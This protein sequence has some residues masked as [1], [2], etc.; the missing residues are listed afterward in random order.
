MS[1]FGIVLLCEVI[2]VYY[3]YVYGFMIGFEWIVVM[4]G[5]L[6]VL[7]FV[8]F[9]LVGCD[10]E[11]LMFDLLYLCNWYFVVVVEGCLVF[12]LSGLDVCF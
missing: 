12:V 2:V 7:L 1:V 3:V 6:V 8:C 11:V 5:V 4:V 9:V 10:D